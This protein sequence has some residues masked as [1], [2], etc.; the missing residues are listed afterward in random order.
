MRHVLVCLLLWVLA[1]R[2][3]YCEHPRF[4][5]VGDYGDAD[6]WVEASANAKAIQIDDDAGNRE[7]QTSDEAERKGEVSVV[8]E[9]FPES[10]I[11]LF[12]T[13]D[14]KS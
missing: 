14:N 8:L 12:S 13:A 11:Q 2:P 3:Q 5:D 4:P 6:H 7:R 10:Q 9:S 1:L